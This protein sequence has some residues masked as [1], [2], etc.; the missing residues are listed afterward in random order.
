[1]ILLFLNSSNDT[2]TNNNNNV[3]INPI[4]KII[5]MKKYNKFYE[6]L[7][8]NNVPHLLAKH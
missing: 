6:K 3:L 7:R 4:T 8:N 2:T 5:T 1:M